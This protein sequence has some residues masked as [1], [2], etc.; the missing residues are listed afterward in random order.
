MNKLVEV[1]IDSIY[2]TKDIFFSDY[3]S[4][5]YKLL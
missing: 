2:E 4:H 1:L 5:Y 3:I